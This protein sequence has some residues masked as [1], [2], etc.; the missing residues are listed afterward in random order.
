MWQERIRKSFA[1]VLVV[2]LAATMFGLVGCTQ[3][4]ENGDEGDAEGETE[5]VVVKIG[6][7]TSLTGG[8]ADY[9]ETAAEGVKIAAA[10]LAPFEVDGV[11][12]EIELIIKDD[13]GEP[14]EAPIVAQQLV[15][16]GVAAVIGPLTSGNTNAALPVYDAA[17]IPVISP[18]ASRVDLVMQGYGFFRTAIGDNIQG[19]V[20]AGWAVENGAEKVAV[21]DDRGDYAVGLADVV[22]DTL[23]AEG[24]EVLREEGQEG[25]VD[26][27]A[28]VANMQNFD[29]D[30]VIF[31]GYHRE[32]GL[33]IKQAT[34][35]GM[36]VK[37]MGGDGVKSDDLPGEAG[38]AEN[39][40]GV[41][42]TVGGIAADQ[43]VGWEN[44]LAEYDEA[45]GKAPQPYAET[46]HDALVAI[47]QAIKDA[48]SADPADILAALADVQVTEGTVMGSFTFTD[49]GE[50]QATGDTAGLQTIVKYE[51]TD[52]AWTALAE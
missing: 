27:S 48:G 29:P 42:A 39:V 11:T 35:A 19:A 24:V 45:V 51:M 20:L 52:G 18:S 36:D 2:A 28:Q 30:T 33:L 15:D 3:T 12:Y 23:E 9:G 25:D 46:N 5:T 16:E 50:I 40:A 38:G 7:H 34:E 31:T 4:D 6:V 10:A 26:F 8:L 41:R 37:F 49:S 44:F 22:Q 13:K 32:F 14:A 43:M 1:L 17:G 21:M 47:V